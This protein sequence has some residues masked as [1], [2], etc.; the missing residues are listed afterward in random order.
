MNQRMKP[1]KLTRALSGFTL[2]SRIATTRWLPTLL[3]CASLCA[4][5]TLYGQGTAPAEGE[6]PQE[7]LKSLQE[8]RKLQNSAAPDLKLPIANTVPGEDPY[9]QRLRSIQQ[10]MELIR[11]LVQQKQAAEEQA[12]LKAYQNPAAAGAE[13]TSEH[14]S[15]AHGET[16]H[17]SDAHS[18]EHSG[19]ASTATAPPAFPLPSLTANDETTGHSTNPNKAPKYVGETVVPSAVDPLE[20]ANSLFQTGNYDLALKTYLAVADKV[21]KPQDAIWTDYFVASCHRILGDLPA[22]E[23][24]YRA[25]V[26]SRRPTRP[27]EAA[28]WW[29]DNVERRKSIA[30]TLNDLDASLKAVSGEANANGNRK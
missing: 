8:F 1:A 13:S 25:L 23:K 4:G 2:V 24:G 27:V 10:R 28:R 6:L 11:S 14:S 5:G 17:G 29:L 15:Q 16:E 3:L 9:Q 30:A 26:E 12:R 22:A 18:A 20:L 21:D 19:G 7:L